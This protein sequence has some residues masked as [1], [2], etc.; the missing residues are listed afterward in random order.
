MLNDSGSLDYAR[1][2]AQNFADE[3]VKTLSGQESTNAV[4]AME[5]IALAV[6]KR[7]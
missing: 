7:A 4:Q 3:A 2:I 5:K 1:G 6:G